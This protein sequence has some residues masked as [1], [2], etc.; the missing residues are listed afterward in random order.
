MKAVATTLKDV[1]DHLAFDLARLP[2]VVGAFLTVRLEPKQLHV[3]TLL[4]QRDP[5]TERAL[6]VA[7][8]QLATTFSSI[9]FD[10]TS[11]HLQG[12]DPQ[13]F[14][15]EGAHPVKLSDPRVLRFFQDAIAARAHAGT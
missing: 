3:W 15:P 1:Q 4:D 6:A 9:P 13:Q 12:R 7:E 14:V 8:D 10:F 11:V 5:A 2:H